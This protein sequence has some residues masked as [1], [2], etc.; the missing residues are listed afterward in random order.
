MIQVDRVSKRFGRKAALVDVSFRVA[1]GEIAALVGPNGAG[2]TT[3]MRILA[4]FLAADAGR[5]AIAGHVLPAARVA[6]CARLGYL[7]EAA[8]LYGEMRV[9]EYLRFRARLKG[10]ARGAVGERV[11]DVTARLGLLD[12]RRV[13][14]SRLSRGFR[15]RVGLADALIATPPV[16]LLDE[17][18]AGLDPVQM[19]EVRS[20]LSDLGE[21]C[22]VLLSSHLLAEVEAVADRVVVLVGGRVVADASPE[23][24]AQD[25]S[26]EDVIVELSGRA[27]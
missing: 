23:E 12:Q 13:L 25:G 16:L 11:A 7:P 15:Q 26:L 22:A 8:P 17:P 1:A 27:R 3:A 6:A 5:V 18:T 24:L 2:K 14:V 4:G 10:V 20:L 19:R 9:D 21:G